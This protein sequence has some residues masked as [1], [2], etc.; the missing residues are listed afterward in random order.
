VDQLAKELQNPD[1]IA[2]LANPQ[3]KDALRAIFGSPFDLGTFVAIIV[4][5]IVTA[6]SA[7]IIFLQLRLDHERSRRETAVNLVREW[8][9]NI[10]IETSSVISLVTNFS[11][12]QCK[13]LAEEKPIYIGN[14]NITKESVLNCLT[15]GFPNVIENDIIQ[16]NA[17]IIRGKYAGYIRFRTMGYLNLLESILCA[18][19]S[20]IAR[21]DIIEEQFRFLRVAPGLDLKS[22]RQAM[23]DIRGQTNTFP[24]IS[25]FT[26]A[27]R[28]RISKPLRLVDGL[29]G[30]GRG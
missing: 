22:F 4:T 8:T 27:T 1:L 5:S 2:A 12:E 20:G 30:S 16:D 29:W 26:D 28:N 18:W 24:S 21:R 25:N 19:N 13:S 6:L 14:G 3:L 11:I 23:F 10:R 9:L 7:G 15:H 17:L